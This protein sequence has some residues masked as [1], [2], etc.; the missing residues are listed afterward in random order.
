MESRTV[1]THLCVA[2]VMLDFMELVLHPKNNL[3][4]YE[5]LGCR[6][7]TTH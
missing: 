3:N 4:S 7:Q 5:I 1:D 6:I 2:C